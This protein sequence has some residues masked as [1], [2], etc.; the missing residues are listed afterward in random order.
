MFL[1]SAKTSIFSRE[2]SLITLWTFSA[3]ERGSLI[4]DIK[5][6]LLTRSDTPP[7]FVE[8]GMVPAKMA[9]P[10]TSG[11]DSDCDERQN[12]SILSS[13]IP[14]SV[15]DS[16]FVNLFSNPALLISD[17]NSGLSSLNPAPI[18]KKC[19]FGFFKDTSLAICKSSN[20]L[21]HSELLSTVPT[22]ILSLN[23][24]SNSVSLNNLFV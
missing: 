16:N 12:T 15:D 3:S 8:T 9:S 13:H 20:I 7:T 21:F 6:S 22:K 24:L 11:N 19:V 17:S 1:H 18:I 5:F 23:E 2:L 10:I 4:G 14:K